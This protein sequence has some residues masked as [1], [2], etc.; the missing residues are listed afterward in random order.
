MAGHNVYDWKYD[1]G[2]LNEIK[3]GFCSDKRVATTP[4][5]MD[6]SGRREADLTF[7]KANKPS[8]DVT[9]S[10]AWKRDAKYGYGYSSG[11]YSGGYSGGGQ[12][13]RDGP[14]RHSLT[15]K[16]D[17]AK[18]KLASAGISTAEREFLETF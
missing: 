16:K 13:R 14:Q 4:Q 9:H 1:L 5:W 3:V 2:E 8:N 10:T 7:V 11:R 18:R 17:F 12:Y 6:K 15:T